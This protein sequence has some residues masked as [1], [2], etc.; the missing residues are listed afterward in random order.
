MKTFLMMGAL[1]GVLSLSVGCETTGSTNSE[2]SYGEKKVEE[3]ADRAADRTE[4]KVDQRIDRG[5]DRAID[6]IFR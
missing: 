5:I 6:N 3:K 4:S 2:P 1:V